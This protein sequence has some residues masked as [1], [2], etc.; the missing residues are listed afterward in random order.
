MLVAY[1]SGHGYGHATRVAE[2][3][4]VVREREPRL[5]IT[6]VSSAPA[7]L[8]HAVVKEPLEVRT[9]ECDV[10]L[11]Q[12]DALTLDAGATAQHWKEFHAGNGDRVDA[13]WRWLH[14][15]GARVILGDV[16]PLAFEAAAEVG[17]PSIALANFSWDWIYRHM[18]RELAALTAAADWAAAAYARAGLLLRLPFAGD[19]S[20]FPKAVDIPL[21]ARR[22]RVARPEV[23]RLLGLGAGPVALVSFGGV[24]LGSFAPRVLAGIAEVQFV[25]VG[26][27]GPAPPNVRLVTGA[28]MAALGLRYED[29]VGAADVVVTKPGYGIVSDAIG[30]GVRIVYTERG[31]FPEYPIL[32]AGMARHVPS[33]HVSNLDLMTGNLREPLRAVL[34]QPVPPPPDLSGAAA[35]AEWLLETAARSA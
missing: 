35:A 33:A 5:G 34:A 2:V 23:R 28:E 15:A 32:V 11:V 22:P 7:G 6:V 9:L 3:L 8:F 24:G 21:I 4:R 26:L 12:K 20:A 18:A 16:P 19:L 14:H 31:D 13:E 27:P 1:V 17:V 10:G 25:G 30:A 29:V